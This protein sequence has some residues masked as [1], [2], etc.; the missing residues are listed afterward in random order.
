MVRLVAAALWYAEQGIPVFPVTPKAKKPPLTRH[1]LHDA[2]LEA[3][4]IRGWWS[5]RP[6]ANIGLATGHVVDVVDIDG[7]QGQRSRAEHW[8]YDEACRE[9]GNQ[10]P[11]PEWWNPV[12]G[13]DGV[14]NRFEAVALGKVATP[15]R[16]G[17]H[18]YIPPTGRKNGTNIAPG[19]D[20]RG[21]GGYVIAAPS[22][23]PQG[24]Y[25]W[26]A[27]LQLPSVTLEPQEAP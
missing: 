22:S 27:P 11:P 15:R 14:F 10:N 13:H 5:A 18:I 4:Q 1:G 20:Y 3:D 7:P 23:T 19:V 12:C 21:L 9:A 25:R 8:C 16:G 17:M 2:T 24:R 6:D 26:I